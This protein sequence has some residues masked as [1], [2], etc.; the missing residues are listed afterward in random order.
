MLEV[1]ATTRLMHFKDDVAV[2]VRPEGTGSSVHMRSKSRVGKG[3]LGANA[4]RIRMFLSE[5]SKACQ[6]P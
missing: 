3:D 2:E 1:V 4:K 5:L 6:A